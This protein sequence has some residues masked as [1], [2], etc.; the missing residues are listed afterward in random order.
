[1]TSP[2]PTAVTPA[3]PEP[4]PR[5]ILVALR[6]VEGP[7]WV[8]VSS[9]GR[10]AMQTTLQPGFA[11]TFTAGRRLDLWLGNAGA[12]RVTLN[13]RPVRMSGDVY[14]ASFVRQKNRVRIVPYS[15]MR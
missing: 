11:D 3:A 7:S 5:G 4:T 14:R 12:V 2:P 1:V 6:V 15:A 9:G 10:V 13:G 8:R